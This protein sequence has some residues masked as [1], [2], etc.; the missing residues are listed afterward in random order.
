MKGC[1]EGVIRALLADKNK[2]ANILA[3]SQYFGFFSEK[4]KIL[5]FILAYAKILA[6]F[7]NAKILAYSKC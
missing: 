3:K 1:Y 5:A 4:A 6:F 7:E 2:K